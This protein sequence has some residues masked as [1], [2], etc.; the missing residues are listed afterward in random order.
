[1]S[2]VYRDPRDVSVPMR[3]VMIEHLNGVG[4]A[5]IRSN[6]SRDPLIRLKLAHRNKT[7]MALLRCGFLR[8]TDRM[9][10]ITDRG[11]QALAVMLADYA[12]A[13]AKA[14]GVQAPLPPQK[15]EEM[16]VFSPVSEGSQPSPEA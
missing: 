13:L 11:R 6:M 8:A 9:T 12:E 10:F 4:C 3:D 5:I 1:M 15:H 7:V 14:Q 16:M 2:V